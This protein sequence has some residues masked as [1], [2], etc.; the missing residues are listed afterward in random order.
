LVEF[1]IPKPGRYTISLVGGFRVTGFYINIISPSQKAV[2]ISEMF[3]KLKFYKNAN[4]AVTYYEFEAEEAG[5]YSIRTITDK[6]LVK[7]SAL[8]SKSLFEKE[9]PHSKLYLLIKEYASPLHFIFSLIL[10]FT[11]V[12]LL[13]LNVCYL[14]Y[15][16]QIIVPTH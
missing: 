3:S 14:L 7:P 16:L 2:E 10:I 1:T 5:A 15:K 12:F 11:G 9:V 8:L 13:L 6:L 4:L